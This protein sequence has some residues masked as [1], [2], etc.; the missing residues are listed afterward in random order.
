MICEASSSIARTSSSV[1]ASS[2]TTEATMMRADAAPITLAT[3]VSTKWTICASASGCSRRQSS[4]RARACSL[5]AASAAG[6]PT[7]RASRLYSCGAEAV[8]RQKPASSDCLECRKTSTNR[9]AWRCSSALGAFI[10]D[11]AP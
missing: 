10:S 2:F 9:L 8:P 11:T 5:N 4:P 1:S 7:K 3:C 6:A